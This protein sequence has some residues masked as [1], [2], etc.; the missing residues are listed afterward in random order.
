MSDKDKCCLSVFNGRISKSLLKYT[1]PRSRYTYYIY[2]FVINYFVKSY[3]T[4]NEIVF[5][6]NMTENIKRRYFFY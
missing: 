2:H 1:N 6:K 3:F 5:K 4:V